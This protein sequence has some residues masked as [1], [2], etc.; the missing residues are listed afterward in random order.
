MFSVAERVSKFN[1]NRKWRLFRRLVRPGPEL[2]VLD[3]GF[4]DAEY[5][6]N[7][8]FLEKHYPFMDRITALGVEEG[9]LFLKRYPAVQVVTYGGGDFPFADKTF[10][11]C[12]SNAVLEHVGDEAQQAGFLREVSR[13][14][15]AAFVSTPNRLFPIEVHTR[16]PILHLVSNRLFEAYLRRTGREWACGNYMRLLSAEDLGGLL[17]KAGVRSY[18]LIRNRLGPFTL[19]F[20]ILLGKLASAG[21]G[22]A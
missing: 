2:S 1:R 11:V 18:R 5:S 9:R 7:D 16:T 15:K 22:R 6:P 8:N 21:H 12:W 20:V 13:V 4:S 19:D 17:G 10:D 14:S 3:A